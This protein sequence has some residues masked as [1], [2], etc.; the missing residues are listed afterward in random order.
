MKEIST[1]R[2]IL[3]D[4][5]LK[6][7]K[8][9]NS[10]LSVFEKNAQPLTVDQIYAE[11]VSQNTAIN[12]STIYRILKTLSEKE[13]ITKTTIDGDNKALFE[14]NSDEHR[15]HLVCI[16]CKEIT[17]VDECPFEEYEKKLKEKMGFTILGHKLEIYGVCNRCKEKA[18]GK[19]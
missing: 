19:K 13:I 12:L 14:L 1:H 11:L 6:N 16:E 8:H 10:I 18:D 4:S 17:M 2:E 3:K 15:H 5:G 7:T 9:R